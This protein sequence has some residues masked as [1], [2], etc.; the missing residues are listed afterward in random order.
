MTGM[1]AARL[2]AQGETE[3]ALDIFEGLAA[4]ADDKA[5][6]QLGVFHYEGTGGEQ[7]YAKAMDW[8]LKVFANQNAD[9]FVN[10]GVMHRDGHAAPTNKKIAYCVFLTIHMCGLGSQSTQ[11]RSNRCLRMVTEKLSRDDIKDCLSNYTPPDTLP[12]T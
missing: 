7:N 1:D 3:E 10:L 4:K 5:M 6:V 2:M 8:W 11:L 9:A 12:R